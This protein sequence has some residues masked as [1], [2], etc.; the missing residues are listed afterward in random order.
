[1]DDLQK[2]VEDLKNTLT[3]ILQSQT[4]VP[5]PATILPESSPSEPV[6]IAAQPPLVPPV[7]EA[8]AIES[9]G[10]TVKPSLEEPGKESPPTRP[11]PKS[12]LTGPQSGNALQAELAQKLLRWRKSFTD[13]E[14]D[15]DQ[16]YDDPSPLPA[17]P[18]VSSAASSSPPPSG[19]P[20]PPPKIK[21]F[22]RV[23][24]T[25]NGRQN[26]LDDIRTGKKLKPVEP[27]V[28]PLDLGI[29]SGVEEKI[30]K[31]FP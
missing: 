15:E 3:E 7:P 25:A 19:V 4:P 10:P 11:K 23:P 18:H 8:S 31:K 14:D 1:M 12:P 6:M 24:T 22:S 9:T 28:K 2:Q 13:T 27:K 30:R 5:L 29:M 16:E 21:T 20:P 26:L 17:I